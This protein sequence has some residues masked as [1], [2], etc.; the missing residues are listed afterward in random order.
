M[1]IRGFIN[2]VKGE[3]I[4]DDY[5]R[6]SPQRPEEPSANSPATAYDPT[7]A[8]PP[9]ARYSG[10]VVNMSS[11]SS[12][13]S[14]SSSVKASE[15]AVVLVNPDRFESAADIADHL[16]ADRTVILNL[17]QTNKDVARRMVDFLSGVAYAKEGRIK[18]IANSTYLIIPC[19]VELMGDLVDE[20]GNSSSNYF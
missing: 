6:E 15:L 20:I 10:N 18:K 5:D 3:E 16:K 4:E 17:E 8:D 11:S 1:G 2:W 12:V 19:N 14:S 7:P 13:S 9:V